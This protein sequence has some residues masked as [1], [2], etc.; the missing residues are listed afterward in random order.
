[1]SGIKGLLD[2]L[3]ESNFSQIEKIFKEMDF[4]YEALL[5]PELMRTPSPSPPGEDYEEA[6]K[7]WLGKKRQSKYRFK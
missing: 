4:H 1:M 2:K 3:G 5:T 7:K 6:K